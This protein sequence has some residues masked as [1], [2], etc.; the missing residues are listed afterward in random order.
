MTKIFISKLSIFIT[1]LMGLLF[2]IIWIKGYIFTLNHIYNSELVYWKVVDLKYSNGWINA[3]PI[4]E[5]SYWWK[6]YQNSWNIYGN[7]HPYIWDNIEVYCFK[8][9]PEKIIINSFFEK[10]LFSTIFLIVWFL[11]L[12]FWLNVIYIYRK[13]KK[14][15]NYIKS[16]WKIINTFV[17]NILFDYKIKLNWKH[18]CVIETQYID[19]LDKS[20]YN[21]KSYNIFIDSPSLIN[22]W[23]EIKVFVDPNDYRKYY[24][25]LSFL[26]QKK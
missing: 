24:V 7:P 18:P 15:I 12:L 5:Y 17:I 13:D 11:F 6:I 19:D 4:I 3:T 23:D 16:N 26:S 2:T 10:Y 8:T 1:I 20:V 25:D 9:N 22:I 21:F 14:F